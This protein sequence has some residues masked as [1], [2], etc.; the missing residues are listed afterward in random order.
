MIEQIKLDELKH[1]LS[2]GGEYTRFE[3]EGY[4]LDADLLRDLV[5]SYEAG[6]KLAAEEEQRVWDS[7][8]DQGKDEYTCGL[9]G[10]HGCQG[11]DLGR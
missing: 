1:A 5:K 4:L 2:M 6:V 7:G 11:C 3:V 10:C 9:K 8:Y